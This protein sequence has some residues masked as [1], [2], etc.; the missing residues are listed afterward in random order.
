MKKDIQLNKQYYRK[1]IH[2]QCVNTCISHLCFSLLGSS[3][4]FIIIPNTPEAA[5]AA[6]PFIAYIYRYISD[7]IQEKLNNKETFIERWSYCIARIYDVIEILFFCS[8]FF[9]P[10]NC[11]IFVELFSLGAWIAYAPLNILYVKTSHK[12]VSHNR[13]LSALSIA[14]DARISRMS[15]MFGLIGAGLNTI[16]FMVFEKDMAIYIAICLYIVTRICDAIT[17]SIERNYLLKSFE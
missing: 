17:N 4:T 2:A 14:I 13:H 3:L 1:F 8:I 12:A 10:N 5:Y 9:I 7:Y 11:V 15:T 6:I 16:L